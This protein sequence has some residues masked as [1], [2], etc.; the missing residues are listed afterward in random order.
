[1]LNEIKSRFLS[2]EKIFLVFV[3][4]IL[5][6]N[7]CISQQL[8]KK[9]ETTPLSKTQDMSIQ[10]P[11]FDLSN[12][13]ILKQ[14][15]PAATQN[16]LIND[17]LM[18][19][20][21][22]VNTYVV[23]PNDVF[24]LG[25]W[26]VLNQAIPL[27]VSPEGSLIIPSV[28]E[29]NISGMTLALAKESVIAKVKHRFIAGDITLT[30]ISPRKFTVT[31]T[32]VGQGSY[33]MSAVMRAS[34]LIAFVMSDSLSLMR[35]GT[36]PGERTRF[37]VRNITLTRKNGEKYRIDLYKYFATQ[38]EKFNPYLREGD[39]LN[40][41]KYDVDAVFLGV[42]GAVQFPGTFEYIEGDDLE[43]AMQ[44]CRGAT[45]AANMD[46]ILISRMDPSGNKMTNVYVKY[47][48]NKHML[49]QINDRV[50]VMSST[51]L[52]KNFKVVVLGEVLR[53]GPYPIAVNST[54]ISDIIK[55]TG[56]FTPN[57]SLATSELYRK[58]DTLAIYSNTKQRFDTLENLYTQRLN[59]IIS[60]KE[61][62]EYYDNE[63][64]SR[65]GRVNIDFEKLFLKGDQSQDVSL[66]DGDFI[67]VG[68]D[69][70]QVYVYGQVN[71]PGYVPYKEGADYSYYINLAGG[72]GE[73]ADEGEVRVIKFKSR[74]WLDPDDAKIE[75]E[76]FIYVPKILKHDF[77]YDIDLI[78]K[79]SSVLV[80]IITLTLL[81]IQAQK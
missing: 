80:S 27:V 10:T 65:I 62:K 1:M 59:D 8:E 67:V 75:S 50:Y 11:R 44:L 81:V 56:G 76:D 73:R 26:G 12:M 74:E 39:V 21:V 40:L 24:S 28:G 54:K 31:V 15:E 22:N 2:G 64:K 69:R 7:A 13:D 43:T 30:L 35:S 18:E 61:E 23:G 55:E 72:Y 77:A 34:R 70:K 46:S 5:A 3:F 66:L 14:I 36:S 32:G 47:E 52:R 9:T 41:P 57:V 17:Q 42:D 48:E 78:A 51:E 20:P 38:D 68:T 45:T 37:S 29:V 25:I 63:Y 71:K 4:V 60:S 79:V 33:P 16:L 6:A 49:L 53:P 19:G 58:I